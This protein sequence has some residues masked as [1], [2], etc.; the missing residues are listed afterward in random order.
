MATDSPLLLLPRPHRYNDAAAETRLLPG[1]LSGA[2]AIERLLVLRAMR[3]DRVPAALAAWVAASLG[4]S[5]VQQPPYDMA[6]TY[7]ESS[8]STPI[9]FVL[10]AGVDP[11]PWVESLAHKFD[12]TAARGMFANISMGQGQEAPAEATLE[13]L[14]SAGGWAFLQNLHLMQSWGESSPSPPGSSAPETQA[15][16]LTPPHSSRA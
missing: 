3:P 12:I 1:E 4:E 13:R 5:Y 16:L 10:F 8:A 9:F 15:L 14:A 11:T 7:G 2:T 6:A